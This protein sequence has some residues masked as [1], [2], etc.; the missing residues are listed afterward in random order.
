MFPLRGRI[1]KGDSLGGVQS[2]LGEPSR[3]C[4]KG[5]G[6]G[7][8]RRTV[9]VRRCS[10]M[11]CL[12]ARPTSAPLSPWNAGKSPCEVSTRPSHPLHRDVEFNYWIGFENFHSF[13][14]ML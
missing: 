4:Q 7:D 11:L 12:A 14:G 10:R 5:E 13:V 9:S 2:Q 8:M 6:E 1:E 3:C